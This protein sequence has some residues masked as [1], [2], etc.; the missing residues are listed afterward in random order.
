VGTY[1][2]TLWQPDGSTSSDSTL[3]RIDAAGQVIGTVHTPTTATFTDLVTPGQELWFRVQGAGALPSR[4][5]N[6]QAH[7]L[8][9]GSLMGDFSNLPLNN[10]LTTGRVTEVTNATI[11]SP[12]YTSRFTGTMS[13]SFTGH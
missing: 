11:G 8:A 2:A 6:A 10:I 5:Y 7:T 13:F 1:E 12:W 9:L 3:D 4:I